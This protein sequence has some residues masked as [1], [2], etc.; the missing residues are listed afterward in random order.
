MAA[1][2]S[3]RLAITQHALEDT[4]ERL[5]DFPNN[6]EV[7]ALRA[8]AMSYVR[9]INGWAIQTP[10]PEQRAALMKCVLDLNVEV[11]ALARRAKGPVP[12]KE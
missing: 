4:L 9:A 11:M 5:E 3:T 6:P 8:K 1:A 7:R 2:K 12:A 10:S